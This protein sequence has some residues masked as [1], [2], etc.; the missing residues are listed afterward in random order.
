MTASSKQERFLEAIRCLGWIGSAAIA[1]GCSRWAHGYWMRHDPTYPERFTD[2]KEEFKDAIHVE[3]H[4][5]AVVGVDVPVYYKGAVVGYFKKYSDRLLLALARAHLPEY[6]RNP[7]PKQE[8]YEPFESP[9]QRAKKIVAR[10][11][12]LQAE[13][14][15]P[16][17]P[18]TKCPRC[19]KCPHCE[20][21]GDIE[22]QALTMA[23]D[24]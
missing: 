12:Q 8:E 5:R 18:P 2:A 15:L 9:E 7:P 6:G 14:R 11:R 23:D 21:P 1:A 19:P 17:T 4:R 10:I 24:E 3:I 13:G 20:Q 22:T 16:P